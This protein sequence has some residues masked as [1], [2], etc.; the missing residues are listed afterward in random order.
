[1]SENAKKLLTLLREKKLVS[2]TVPDEA[3]TVEVLGDKTALSSK[4][5][6]NCELDI[7]QERVR[8]LSAQ[9]DDG[10]RKE[11][12]LKDKLR[13]AEAE[14]SKTR[15]ENC[16]SESA[17]I[18]RLNSICWDFFGS[19][20]REP[21]TSPFDAKLEFEKLAEEWLAE[22]TGAKGYIETAYREELARRI[23]QITAIK[24]QSE[25]IAKL[26]QIE[27]IEWHQADVYRRW[28]ESLIHDTLLA[29]QAT[30]QAI[31]MVQAC[32]R[33]GAEPMLVGLAYESAKSAKDVFDSLYSSLSTDIVYDLN[34]SVDY[35]EGYVRSHRAAETLKA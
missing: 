30:Q 18:L 2:P 32:L 22:V 14:L 24:K 17:Q 25:A 26:T 6:A 34:R 8:T 31:R 7:L 29:V 13:T 27:S 3:M 21:T 23:S 16:I 20:E 35:A 11:V 28:F 12:E 5:A 33:A 10:F 19:L 9:V 4:E 1:M 15:R